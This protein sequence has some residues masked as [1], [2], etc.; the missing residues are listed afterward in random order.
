MPLVKTELSFNYL[1][2]KS[3]VLEEAPP[4]KTLNNSEVAFCYFV[5]H[6]SPSNIYLIIDAICHSFSFF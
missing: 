5:L 4:K 6:L 3:A 1:F 2:N